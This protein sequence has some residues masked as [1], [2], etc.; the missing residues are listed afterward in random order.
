MGF[1]AI[2]EKL[3]QNKVLLAMIAKSSAESVQ[4]LSSASGSQG[5]AQVIPPVPGKET[6]YISDGMRPVGPYEA[7]KIQA[8]FEKGTINKETHILKQG[9]AEWKKLGDV[10]D[11]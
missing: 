4:S 2:V 6:Y 5:A 9:G 10:F 11:V 1:A 3:E 8:L 7:E